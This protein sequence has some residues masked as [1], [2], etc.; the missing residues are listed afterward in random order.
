VAGSSD[1]ID[2][3]AL[4]LQKIIDLQSM[5]VS[6]QFN[7]PDFMQAVVT[8]L[9]ALTGSIAPH[10]GLRLRAANSLSGLSIRNSE[11]RPAPPAGG[12]AEQPGKPRPADGAAQSPAVQGSTR[13]GTGT[14]ARSASGELALMYFDVDHFKNVN[15]TF[16]HAAGDTLLKGFVLRIKALIRSVDTFAR[17]GGDEFALRSESVPNTAAAEAVAEKILEVTQTHF[18]LE[19][20]IVRVSTSIGV[21]TVNHNSNITA[22]DLIRNAD[23]AM[24][25]AKRAGRNAFRTVHKDLSATSS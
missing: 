7:L 6:L 4:R 19:G 11:D 17:L 9:Q 8:Q 13:A 22:D 12:G 21:V 24:Y 23:G 1:R 3:T 18:E 10:T 16:G 2:P 5:L 14:H 15:D 20:H 25:E